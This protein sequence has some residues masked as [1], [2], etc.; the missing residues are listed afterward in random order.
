MLPNFLGV[1]APKAGT[2]TL[3]VLLKDHPDVFIPE[4]KE[5]DFFSRDRRFAKGLS[6]YEKK[7]FSG[8]KGERAVG[9]ISPVYMDVEAV[10]ERIYR[11]LGPQVKLLFMLRNPVD[12]AYSHY[13][14][15]V[16]GLCETESFERALEL[17]EERVKKLGFYGFRN[18][19][20]VRRGFYDIYIKRYLKFFKME[21]M[22]IMLLEDFIRDPEKFLEE[23][24]GFLGVD[25]SFRPSNLNV[26]ANYSTMPRVW[27]IRKIMMHKKL[28]KVIFPIKSLRRWVKKKESEWNSRKF[29]PPPMSPE[30]RKKL[31]EIFRPHIR[32]L[33][34]IIGR[35][36]SHWLS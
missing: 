3:F 35:D 30:T 27:F 5:A 17:E 8:W 18:F 23:L 16:R 10:P 25:T 26:R 11:S 21:N 13:W 22:H 20:Y 31:V 4:E 15:S 34:S 28:R 9:E 32:E 33:E 29:T 7:Y 6:W 14:K 19:G 2:T 36:L 24:Y 1:G 12:R